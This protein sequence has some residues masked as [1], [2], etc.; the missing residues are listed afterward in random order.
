VHSH[1]LREPV[2]VAGQIIPW[3]FPLLMAAKLG[4]ALA[5]GNTVVLK[6]AE[7]T[8]PTALPLGQLL[9]EAGCPRASSPS[10]PASARRPGRP[11]PRNDVDKVALTRSTEVGKVIVQRRRAT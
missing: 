11:W 8:Q 10:C 5:T 4:P 1:P 9:A 3:N 7:Q 6:P 2:G